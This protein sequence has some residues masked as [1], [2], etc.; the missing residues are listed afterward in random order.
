MCIRDRYKAMTK[1]QPIISHLNSDVNLSLHDTLKAKNNDKRDAK[2]GN[3]LLNLHDANKRIAESLNKS[4]LKVSEK[5]VAANASEMSSKPA[6][7]RHKSAMIHIINKAEL[8]SPSRIATKDCEVQTVDMPY[9]YNQVEELARKAVR[10]IVIMCLG[11]ITRFIRNCIFRRTISER[12]SNRLKRK[13]MDDTV[14]C[15]NLQVKSS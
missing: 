10:Q 6:S 13:E 9:G 2:I 12:I 14:T 1:E 7:K 3:A 15:V 11:K 4:G 8:N 5:S